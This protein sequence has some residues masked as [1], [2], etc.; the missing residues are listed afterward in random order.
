MSYARFGKNSDVYVN[1]TASINCIGCKLLKE[2]EFSS[3]NITF[4]NHLDLLMHLLEHKK[5]GHKVMKT[6]LR[7][8]LTNVD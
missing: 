8:V 3:G 4:E 2:S 5:A 7:D 6:T 1:V